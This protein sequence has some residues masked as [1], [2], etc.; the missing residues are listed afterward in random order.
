MTLP[1]VLLL[2]KMS[3]CFFFINCN[4]ILVLVHSF[5]NSNLVHPVTELSCFLTGTSLER[6]PSPL[7]YT[8]P[9]ITQP[10]HKTVIH[11]PQPLS[12]SGPG[13]LHGACSPS[14]QWVTI[15]T[16]STSAVFLVLVGSGHWQNECMNQSLHLDIMDDLY[17]LLYTFLYF[18]VFSSMFIKNKY[19]LESG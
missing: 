17:S 5:H 9:W 3:G 7:P 15:T 6:N 10:R 16:Y 2:G 14:L 11:S 12:L 8:L 18:F 19:F 4:F 1:N 13:V